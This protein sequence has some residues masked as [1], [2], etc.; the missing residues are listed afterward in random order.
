MLCVANALSCVCLL[1]IAGNTDYEDAITARDVAQA[2]ECV[3]QTVVANGDST[4]ITEIQTVRSI[5]EAL[6]R[7][8]SDGY[9]VV[10]TKQGAGG[11]CCTSPLCCFSLDS[12][13][14]EKDARVLLK[15]LLSAIR[16][17]SVS[18]GIDMCV[19]FLC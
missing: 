3:S 17:G 7:C 16:V 19:G 2:V 1:S 9:H 10:I 14:H 18:H 5:V 4:S 8:V 6:C 13:G 11:G 15:P 12:V